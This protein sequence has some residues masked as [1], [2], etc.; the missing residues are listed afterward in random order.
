[1]REP[2]TIPLGGNGRLYGIAAVMA[3]CPAGKTRSLIIKITKTLKNDTSIYSIMSYCVFTMHQS[4]G[5]L[6]LA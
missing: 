3:Q 2:L 6:D 5:S 4:A 1:M